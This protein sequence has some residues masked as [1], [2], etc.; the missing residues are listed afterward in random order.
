VPLWR[1]QRVRQTRAPSAAQARGRDGHDAAQGCVAVVSTRLQFARAARLMRIALGRTGSLPVDRRRQHH[2]RATTR[3]DTSKFFATA[4]AMYHHR[5]TSRVSAYVL[6]RQ[7]ASTVTESPPARA[8]EHCMGDSL[9][10]ARDGDTRVI[11]T[12]CTGIRERTHRIVVPRGGGGGRLRASH[13]AGATDA[14]EPR[15]PRVRKLRSA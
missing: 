2:A 13:A 6:A 8:F 3:A 1:L 7:R 12:R 14:N 11:R 5:P 4:T 10:S 9:A 15:E